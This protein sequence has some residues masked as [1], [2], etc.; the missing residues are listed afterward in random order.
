MIGWAVHN[1]P[2]EFANFHPVEK[3]AKHFRRPDVIKLAFEK[4]SV[5][6]ALVSLRTKP[7]EIERILPP[8]A[9]LQ[10]MALTYLT[11]TGG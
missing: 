2:N 10:L 9:K 6:E 5:K 3:F 7:A 1:G 8:S 11:Q 4:G